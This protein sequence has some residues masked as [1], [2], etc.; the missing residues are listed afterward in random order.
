LKQG[1]SRI[2]MEKWWSDFN[3][4]DAIVLKNRV[5]LGVGAVFVRITKKMEVFKRLYFEN[6]WTL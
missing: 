2:E 5:E 1:W 3:L 6:F 4:K